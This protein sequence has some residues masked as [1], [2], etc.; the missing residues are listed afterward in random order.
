VLLRERKHPEHPPDAGG[1]LMLVDVIADGP[2]AGAGRSG[3]RQ[4]RQRGAR[5][6]ARAVLVLD[7]MP[8]AGRAEVLAQ[9]LAG[10]GEQTD[11]EAIPLDVDLAADPARRRAVVG[12]L[13]FDA[14]VEVHRPETVAVVPK[15][16]EGQRA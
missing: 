3:S 1:A 16:L 8:A 13:D 5:R 6:A 7:A 2:D 9:Q 10:R 11:V 12:G 4:R 15:G 14:A